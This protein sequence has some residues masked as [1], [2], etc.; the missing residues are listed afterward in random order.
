MRPTL[1]AGDLIVVLPGKVA[2]PRVGSVV[3]VRDPREPSRETVKRVVAV[4]GEPADLAGDVRTVTAGHIAVRGDDARASTDSRRFG[5]VP[6]E[7]VTGRVVARV[8]P[9]PTRVS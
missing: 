2:Q 7:L 8:W 3:L 6:L 1:D 5:P 4:A 9:R